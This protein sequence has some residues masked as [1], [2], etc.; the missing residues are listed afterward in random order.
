VTVYTSNDAR[1]TVLALR[2]IGLSPVLAGSVARQGESW[3]DLDLSVVLIPSQLNLYRLTMRSLGYILMETTDGTDH[4]RRPR[5][6]ALI[7]V[8]W[9]QRSWPQG[10]ETVMSGRIK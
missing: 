4:W 3:H 10:S 5:H 2:A 8:H 7:D 9:T 1:E 6:P